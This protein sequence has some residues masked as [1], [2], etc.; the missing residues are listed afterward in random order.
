MSRKEKVEQAIKYLHTL[1]LLKDQHE[2]LATGEDLINNIWHN[3]I[4]NVRVKPGTCLI[5]WKE[6]EEL[7]NVCDSGHTLCEKCFTQWYGKHDS[8]P[9][10][11][12]SLHLFLKHFNFWHVVS[13]FIIFNI[14]I[15]VA[16][17]F[18][19]HK[20]NTFNY[21]IGLSFIL[22]YIFHFCLN[23]SIFNENIKI[24][25]NIWLL[26]TCVHVICTDTWEVSRYYL[27]IIAIRTINLGK[28]KLCWDFLIEFC[29]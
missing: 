14:F 11:R 20:V 18:S 13:V 4:R 6:D 26:Y 28:L 1:S 29:K 27:I 15:F 12:K 16:T 17:M 10:C 22:F 21:F 9:Y 5:C 25:M 8:C 2:Q 3:L 19:M 23:W 7:I 24:A